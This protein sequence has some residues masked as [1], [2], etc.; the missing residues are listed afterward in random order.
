[1]QTVCSKKPWPAAHTPLPARWDPRSYLDRN[2]LMDTAY[3]QASNPAGS[4][5][6]HG[7]L[8]TRSPAHPHADSNVYPHMHGPG[9][10]THT[11]PTTIQTHVHQHAHTSLC[12]HQSTGQAHICTSPT[13]TVT[14]LPYTCLSRPEPTNISLSFVFS[15][16][17]GVF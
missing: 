13:H 2:V 11:P 17:P 7:D 3:P 14:H 9:T 5:S 12:T 10:H 6:T 16:Y 4:H 15:A 1:M 8:G